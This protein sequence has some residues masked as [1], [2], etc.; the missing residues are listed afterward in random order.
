MV[1]VAADAAPKR[2]RHCI[3]LCCDVD[4]GACLVVMDLSP[5]VVM[6]LA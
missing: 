3:S 1:Y 4:D 6:R 5:W 2:R